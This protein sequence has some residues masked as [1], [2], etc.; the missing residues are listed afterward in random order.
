MRSA[1]KTVNER[2]ASTPELYLQALAQ[3][4]IMAETDL[5]CKPL[6]RRC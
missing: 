3:Y 5:V 2:L 6:S 4:A 1:E